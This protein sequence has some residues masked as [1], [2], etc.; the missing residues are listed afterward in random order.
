M[1]TKFHIGELVKTRRGSK[2][3]ITG[4]ITEV[5]IPSEEIQMLWDSDELH[6]MVKDSKTNEFLSVIERGLERV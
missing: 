1:N 5:I 4:I 2:L 3:K 6:Y